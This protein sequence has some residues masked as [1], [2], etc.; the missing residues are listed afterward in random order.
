MWRM[1]PELSEISTVDAA[2]SHMADLGYQLRREQAAMMGDIHTAIAQKKIAV[3][4]GGTGIG[5]TFAYLIPSL[6]SR[7]PKQR[8]V[9]S[10]ATINLQ[11]QL[12][13]QDLPH[14]EEIL[15]HQWQVNIAKGRRRYVCLSRLFRYHN[16][17]SESQLALYGIDVPS[18]SDQAEQQMILKLVSLFESAQ[19][20]GDRD[21]LDL[22]IPGSLWSKLT[23]DVSGCNNR[24][25]QFFKECPYFLAKKRL[26]QADV[27]I[28]NHDLLL[29]DLSIGGGVLL[30]KPEECLYIIDEAH[31]LPAKAISQFSNALLLKASHEWLGSLAKSLNS[32]AQTLGWS[33]GKTDSLVGVIELLQTS[34][35][36]LC[37]FLQE[38]YRAYARDERWLLYQIPQVVAQWAAD[39]NQHSQKLYQALSD[40][41][42]QFTEQHNEATLPEFEQ[43][44]NAFKF[45]LQRLDQFWRTW[46]VFCSQENHSQPPI[47]R[48]FSEPQSSLGRLMQPDFICHVAVSSASMLLPQFFWQKLAGGAVLCSATLRSLGQFDRYLEQIGLGGDPR[49]VAKAYQSP[50]D[51]QKSQLQIPRMRSLP[52]A[53][54]ESH[55]QELIQ[56]LPNLLTSEQ[57][58]I[59]VLFT[60]FRVMDKVFASLPKSLKNRVLVQGDMA[61]AQLLKQHRESIDL[62][63]SSILFGLQSLAEGVDLPGDYC[64]CVIITKLPFAVPTTPIEQRYVDWLKQQGRNA[65]FEH[66][67]PEASLRLTQWVG[68]LIR[69][70]QDQGRVV[71]LDRRLVT[72]QYGKLLLQGLPPFCLSDGDLIV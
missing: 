3:I 60:S 69:H 36:E 2:L 29:S 7:Q 32:M 37:Q 24:R 66:S 53:G 67:L 46:H 70:E 42:K 16:G 45:F 47:V 13:Q 20:Q 57:R 11:E 68:R 22:A 17:E 43:M 10:T 55:E 5:K 44:N 56:L 1:K 65:F 52:K 27:I 21:Q 49:V 26:A 19:W 25:C 48:W 64:R 14:V 38:N 33:P 6:L 8:V 12:Q 18:V 62:G 63:H 31:H 34:L 41:F 50:F 30:P 39:L 71:I 9:V 40:I 23:T 54:D 28:T 58:G 51:Y 72:K 15:S 4:E 59:L 61:K 35:L